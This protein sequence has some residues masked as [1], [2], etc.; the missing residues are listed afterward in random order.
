LK[1][2]LWA[3]DIND[4][5]LSSLHEWYWKDGMADLPLFLYTQGGDV[6][7][8]A[9]AVDLILANKKPTTIVAVGEVGSA[10]VVVYLAG[11]RRYCTQNARF[12]LHPS[13]ATGQMD[14]VELENERRELDV[15][16]RLFSSLWH[17]RGCLPHSKLLTG[18]FYMDAAEAK[19]YKLVQKIIKFGL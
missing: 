14:V 2:R 18:T 4:A 9:A 1:S 12:F 13:T 7:V 16:G 17:A 10:G 8:A 3:G 5:F 11:R 15:R 19:T 6:G